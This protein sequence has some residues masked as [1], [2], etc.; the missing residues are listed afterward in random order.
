MNNKTKLI[1]RIFPAFLVIIVLSLSAVASYSTS[2][3]KAFFLE[4]A[5]NELMVRAKLLRKQF[6]DILAAGSPDSKYIDDL[7]KNIGDAT[8]TRVTVILPSGSVIGDSFGETDL[9]ENHMARPEIMA[10][11]KNKEGLSRRYS[12][13][14]DKH[15][16][17]IAL[18]VIKDG[19][20]I[21]VVRT[22]VSLSVIDDKISLVRNSILLAMLG[23]SLLA[24][25]VSLFVSRHLTR[26]M[27]EMKKSAAEF[28]RGNLGARMAVP[29]TEELAELAVTINHMA[30]SLDEKIKTCENR[31]RELEAVHVSMQE[32]VIAIDKDQRIITINQAAAKI[33]G[34]DAH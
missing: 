23:T 4:T 34:F 25:M 9:M 18:P 29:D 1:R 11:L 15:M 19:T 10:A 20:P 22:S 12:S 17:Y 7:C 8:G 32:G 33:F 30:K 28:A 5:E 2:Y 31:S 6:A 21:A 16:M 3:F 27:E 26:P 24:G 13:T 14:L